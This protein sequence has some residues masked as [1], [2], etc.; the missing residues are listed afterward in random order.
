M[1]AIATGLKLPETLDALNER[2]SLRIPATWDE[3]IELAD[4]TSYT[5]QFLNDEI[6]I[7]SQATDTHE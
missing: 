4:E 6:I 2:D 3:Y 1:D 7:M 5:I